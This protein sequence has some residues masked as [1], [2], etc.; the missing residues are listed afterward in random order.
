MY[1]Q[2]RAINP[3]KGYKPHFMPSEIVGKSGPPGRENTTEDS[4]PVIHYQEQ[5]ESTTFS[6]FFGRVA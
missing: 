3:A 4:I 2:Y 6:G 5:K 1:L